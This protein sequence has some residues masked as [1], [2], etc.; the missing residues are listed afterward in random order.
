MQ[1]VCSTADSNTTNAGTTVIQV[2]SGQQIATNTSTEQQHNNQK[3]RYMSH[4]LQFI[5]LL[6]Y[7]LSFKNRKP[8]NELNEFKFRTHI[9][10]RTYKFYI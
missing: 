9:N 10:Y 1:T 3:V 8:I 4:K 5:V 7:F 6:N 2:E